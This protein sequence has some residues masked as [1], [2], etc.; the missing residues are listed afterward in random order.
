MRIFPN[1]AKILKKDTNRK[2]L[3]MGNRLTLDPDDKYGPPLKRVRPNPFG[4]WQAPP[5][6][7]LADEHRAATPAGSA[8]AGE[9]PVPHA[10]S[11]APD[12]PFSVLDIIGIPKLCFLRNIGEDFDSAATS[13]HAPLPPLTPANLDQLMAWKAERFGY[14]CPDSHCRKEVVIKTD[15]GKWQTTGKTWK[16]VARLLA[17]GEGGAEKSFASLEDY[18]ASRKPEMTPS[19]LR[20]LLRWTQEH[21]GAPVSHNGDL[22]TKDETPDGPRWVPSLYRLYEI[23]MLITKDPDKFGCPTLSAFRK[24][25]GFPVRG[26]EPAEEAKKFNF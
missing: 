22:W 21:D 5:K 23:N 16:D 17:A 24:H 10:T 14:G 4:T 26:K 1:L 18:V 19:Y 2:E 20:Q 12:K 6:I 13:K 11:A 9:A 3:T 25:H 8:P 7:S 15:D